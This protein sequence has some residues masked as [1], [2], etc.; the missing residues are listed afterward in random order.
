MRVEILKLESISAEEHERWRALAQ[1]ALEPNPFFEP[2]LVLSAHR[3]LGRGSRGLAVA[4]DERGWLACLPIHRPRTWHRLP[5]PGIAAWH[6]PYS[7][8]GTPLVSERSPKEA[9][10]ALLQHLL[11]LPRAMFLGLDLVHRDGLVAEALAA[12]TEAAEARLVRHSEH[13]RAQLNRNDANPAIELALSPKHRR[14]F[15]RLRRRLES[16]LGEPLEVRDRSGDPEAVEAFLE[17]EA[18]GWKGKAGTAFS[19]LES[20]DDFFRSVASEL[21]V[22]GRLELLSLE[23][24][25]GPL[26]MKC[27][28]RAGNGSFCVK[29]AYDERWARY[30]PGVQLEIE[31]VSR[32][33][34]D[35]K[36]NW[37]DSCAGPNNE[38]I[39]RLWADRRPI[40]NLAACRRSP[41]GRFAE[42][43][44]AA[45][46]RVRT[47]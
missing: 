28:V 33:R 30:S 12:A 22:L 39:N 44:I 43:A 13:E 2:E 25:D 9:L 15:E 41:R 10:T 32:F 46:R 19:T 45:S 14:N 1:V 40:V 5:L 4:S 36:L 24:G 16:E 11:R 31:N 42:V 3:T 37:M 38:M 21:A 18:A 20:H 8:L 47:A 34:G 17:L 29:I 27:N 6:H 23:T 35:S 7:F 26:A